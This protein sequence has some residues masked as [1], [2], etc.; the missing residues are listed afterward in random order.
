MLYQA[1]AA[2]AAHADV[3]V[4]SYLSGGVDSSLIVAMANKALGRPI[5]TFTVSVKS[6]G[7]NEESEALQTAQAPRVRAGGR[8]LRARRAARRLPGVDRAPP[9][10]RSSTRRAWACSHSPRSVH[11]HGYKVVLTGEGADE[12]LAGYSWFKI[13]RLTGWMDRIPGLPLGYGLRRLMLKLTGQP[14]FPYSTYRPR[15]RQMGGHNGWFDMYGVM[16]V[17]KLRFFTGAAREEILSKSAL[18]RP[19]TAAGPEPL[20]PVQ[21]A[22]VLRGADHAAGPPAREQGRPDRDALVG[23]GPLRLPRRGR[24]RVHGEAAPAVEAARRVQGQVHRAEGRRAVAAEGSRLAAQADVPRPDGLPGRE[25]GD[26][27]SWIDQVLSP[28]SIRKAGYFDPAAVPGGPRRSCPSPAAGSARTSLEM[29][30]TAVTATQ[31][32]HHLYISGD[33]ADYAIRKSGIRMPKSQTPLYQSSEQASISVSD[34][35]LRD[36][37][38]SN[39]SYAL[40]TLW[41]ERARYAS[42]VLAVT[43]SAVLI[44]L[45]CGLLLGL[46]KITSIPIDNTTAD[47]W[48][49]STAV[50]ERGS[51]QADP[52]LVHH[53]G[54]RACPA[55]ACPSNTSP[56]SRTSPSRSAAP[57]CASSSAASSTTARPGPPTV[58]TKEQRDA[59]TMPYAIIVDE[60]DWKRL[61]LDHDGDKPK[62][63][64]KEVRWSAR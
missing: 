42:G 47:L 63:N 23:R 48:V 22:D 64:G 34:F 29:G 44:A 39:M 37:E 24:D 10:S 59:L 60:S 11:E 62:I 4:V 21:P 41:H 32:W 54:S 30:L 61:E 1:R 36:S 2:A 53:A 27:A 20:A 18:R 31:L 40:Q 33:L 14:A 6:K 16:S 57:N 25:S 26:A 17:N 13:N 49:G 19:R 51:R 15:R 43:F 7:L 50:P 5:P 52:E 28:E 55:S 56:T 12:W 9:S 3:P 46:F 45:Q 58:L 35:E 8:R 38:F